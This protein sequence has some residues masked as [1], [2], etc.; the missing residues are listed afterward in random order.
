MGAGRDGIFVFNRNEIKLDLRDD[1]LI[2]GLRV[3]NPSSA[4]AVMK[5][6]FSD[7]GFFSMEKSTTYQEIKQSVF[8]SRFIYKVRTRDDGLNMFELDFKRMVYL[9][10]FITILL[11]NHTTALILET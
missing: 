4:L 3:V 7:R 5:R 9:I 1:P 10:I 11:P 8:G 2:I 6:P